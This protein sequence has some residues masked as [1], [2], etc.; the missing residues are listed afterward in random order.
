M[1]E[2]ELVVIPLVQRLIIGVV[3]LCPIPL[4]RGD[5]CL[6]LCLSLICEVDIV[7][8]LCLASKCRGCVVFER[9]VVYPRLLYCPKSS[10]EVPCV[11][12]PVWTS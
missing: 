8:A 2:F 5:C 11:G 9:G 10:V 3:A 12:S 6:A 1:K 4:V 7:V